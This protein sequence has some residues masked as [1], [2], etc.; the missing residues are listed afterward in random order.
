MAMH[1]TATPLYSTYMERY[2]DESIDPYGG[3]YAG[4]MGVF[5]SNITQEAQSIRLKLEEQVFAT[6]DQQPHA[7]LSVSGGQDGVPLIHVMHRPSRLVPPIGSQTETQHFV[8]IG[9]VVNKQ[10]PGVVFWPENPFQKTTNIRVAS[11]L[12]LDT[13]FTTD[14]SLEQVGPYQDDA[15][16]TEVVSTR[17]LMYLPP[18]YVPMALANP[19]MT[20][21]EAW[22][23]IGGSIRSDPE[24]ATLINDLKP[25]LDWL[26]V[27]CTKQDTFITVPATDLGVPIYPFPLP[28]NYHKHLEGIL[29]VDVPRWRQMGPVTGNEQVAAAVNSLTTQL[30][31]QEE[32]RVTRAQDNADKTPQKYWGG[33]TLFLNR[34]TGTSQP[35]DLL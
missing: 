25:L 34:V 2:A 6:A 8:F 7:Y 4:V 12:T 33:G 14:P 28:P 19:A 31:V 15:A 22:T 5:K 9:D 27:A 13:A 11:A 29:N 24:A 18:R 26:K 23:L 35:E 3:S 30:K 10:P 32:D 21:K 17:S 20:P 1:S 16:G